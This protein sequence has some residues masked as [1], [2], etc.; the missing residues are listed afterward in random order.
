M[1]ALLFVL[2]GVLPAQAALAQ[3]GDDGDPAAGRKV[4]GMCRTCHGLDGYAVIPIAPHIGGEPASYLRRQLEAFRSGDRVHE[5][6]TIVAQGLSERQILDVTAWY[7]AQHATAEL[8]ADPSGAPELCAGCHGAD[9]IAVIEDAPNL[10]GET[11]MYVDT[12]LKAFRLGKRQSEIM[13]PIAEGLSDEE[14]R[15]AADWYAK[16][17]L[18]VTGD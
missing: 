4:A 9:G 7:A 10:A 13:G 14:I 11:A 18:T 3:D 12:Q 17:K 16:V 5:M 2:G 15:A 8:A 6:M 1:R